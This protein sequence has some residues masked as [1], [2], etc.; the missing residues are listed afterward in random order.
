MIFDFS[1]WEW[2]LLLMA[3]AMTGLSKTG[4]PAVGMLVVPIMAWLFGGRPSTGFLLPML[5]MADIAAVL[6][7]RR[8]ANFRYIFRLMP[9]VLMGIAIGTL[10]GKLFSIDNFSRIIGIMVIISIIMLLLK[11]WFEKMES[12]IH[13]IWFSAFFGLLAGYSTMIANAAGPVMAVY[14]LSFQLK[15]NEFIGTAAWFF[16]LVN[17]IKLPLQIWVWDNISMQTL[18]LNLMLL[19]AILLGAVLGIY[20]V[21]KIPEL[22]YRYLIIGATVLAAIVMVL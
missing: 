10:T 11:S 9:F 13:N 17:L 20:L 2:A 7:Y 12:R 15:K 3:A 22:Y 8:N 6:Y 4:V 19:P 14:L 18:Q 1:I 21:K 5:I 16:M